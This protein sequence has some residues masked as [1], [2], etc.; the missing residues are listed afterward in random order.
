MP[1]PHLNVDKY[2]PTNQTQVPVLRLH[3]RMYTMASLQTLPDEL[4]LGIIQQLSCIRSHETQSTAFRDREGEKARQFENSIRQSTLYKLCLTSRQLRTIATPVLYSSITGSLTW[5][6]LKPLQLFH[7]TITAPVAETGAGRRRLI[8]YLQYVENRLADH[9]GNS[10]SQDSSRHQTRSM[11][12]EYLSLLASVVT[13]ARN[14]QHLNIVSLET[15]DISFWGNILPHID[16]PP[17]Q[18]LQSVCVQVHTYGNM[19]L[20]DKVASFHG[21]CAELTSAPLLVDLWASGF[22]PSSWAHNFTVEFRALQRLELTECCLDIDNVLQLWAACEGLQ[23]I[24]CE[25]AFLMAVETAPKDLYAGLLRHKTTLKTLHLDMREVRFDD[26]F[27][28]P[29][30]LGSLQPFTALESVR[31]CETSLL[32]H[33]WSLT[34]FPEQVLQCRIIEHLPASLKTLTLLVLDNQDQDMENISRLDEPLILWNF[35]DDCQR[36][37]SGLKEIRIEGSHDLH[38]PRTVRAF[39]EI[40]VQFSLVKQARHG[41]PTT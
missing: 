1:E 35:L 31:I 34:C 24:A 41:A 38:A 10:L 5:H 39:E 30:K 6:G 7:R 4:I 25:W 19:L 21:I 9:L 29:A 17:F 14:L 23:H 3:E 8:D 16:T 28:A 12:T 22:T 32:G 2:P 18:R 15:K 33:V 20:S 13:L 40:G 11:A 26:A 37:F 27:V 36:G